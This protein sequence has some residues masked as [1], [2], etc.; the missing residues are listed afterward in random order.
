[1]TRTCINNVF[2]PCGRW[3]LLLQSATVSHESNFCAVGRIEGSTFHQ[4]TSKCAAQSIIALAACRAVCMWTSRGRWWMTAATT[5]WKVREPRVNELF[6]TRP[7][8]WPVFLTNFGWLCQRHV[9]HRRLGNHD[10][11]TAYKSYR[12]GFL[13]NLRITAAYQSILVVTEVIGHIKFQFNPNLS[14]C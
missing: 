10:Y 8:D 6:R 5:C 2:E 12:D 11:N 7:V 9:R 3:T 13:F 4:R 14:V 1:M